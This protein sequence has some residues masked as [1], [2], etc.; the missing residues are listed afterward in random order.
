MNIQKTVFIIGLVGMFGLYSCDNNRVFEENQAI[1]KKEWKYDE[2]KTFTIEI[3]DTTSLYTMFV[4]IR[5]NGNYR[6]SNLFILLGS[7]DPSG[8]TGKQLLEFK[9]AEENGK[10]LGKGIGDIFSYQIPIKKELK[11]G[12]PGK[13]EFTLSQEMRDNPLL[14]VEDIGIRI[15]KAN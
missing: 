10:W 4:N 3:K 8:V 12:K 6:Y 7:K 13:Y 5:H 11:I 9:L 15:E 14:Y 1:N 2:A